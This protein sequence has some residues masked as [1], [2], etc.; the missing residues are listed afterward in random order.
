VLW[1]TDGRLLMSLQH[2]WGYVIGTSSD[3]DVFTSTTLEY[4]V[5]TAPEDWVEG[6]GA[7]HWLVPASLYEDQLARRLAARRARAP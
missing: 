1:N 4:G 3:L 7:G 2:G 5:G 6:L